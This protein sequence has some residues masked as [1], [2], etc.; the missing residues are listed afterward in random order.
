[1][2]FLLKTV[3]ILDDLKYDMKKPFDHIRYLY[4]KVTG[5][6]QYLVFMWKNNSY[7]EWDFCYLYD[8]MEFKLNRM[9]LLLRDHAY[10]MDHEERYKEIQKALAYYHVYK[11]IEDGHYDREN[12]EIIKDIYIKQQEAWDLFHDTLKEYGQGW[13]D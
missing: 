9:S 13:W 2:R 12:I 3:E 4:E 7:R 5:I 11:N 6:W 8:L 10:A 1:M